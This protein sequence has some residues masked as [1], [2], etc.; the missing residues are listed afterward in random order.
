MRGEERRGERRRERAS[1][2]NPLAKRGEFEPSVELLILYHWINHTKLVSTIALIER[3]FE[4][5]SK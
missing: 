2:V 3:V 5:F 1:L 4:S